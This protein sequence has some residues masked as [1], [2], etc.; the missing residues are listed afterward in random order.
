MTIAPF[1]FK[2][3]VACFI[4]GIAAMHIRSEKLCYV[5]LLYYLHNP[6]K[7]ISK[8]IVSCWWKKVQLSNKPAPKPIIKCCQNYLHFQCLHFKHQV[9][10]GEIKV[11]FRKSELKRTKKVKERKA[12][13]ETG[14]R[15]WGKLQG[16]PP[17][18]TNDNK[19]LFYVHIW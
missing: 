15:V 17:C 14:P 11:S 4:T 7:K 3:S 9:F 8:M 13:R 1:L 12:V 6:Q 18:K 2:L 16:S 10:I 5:F 19:G